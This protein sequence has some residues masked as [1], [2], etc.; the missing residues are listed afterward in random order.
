M[1]CYNFFKTYNNDSYSVLTSPNILIYVVLASIIAAIGLEY[2]QD[3]VIL[4]SMLIS[5]LAVPILHYVTNLYKN[6]FFAFIAHLSNLVIFSIIAIIIGF[7]IS[8]TN[9]NLKIFKNPSSQMKQRADST[10]KIFSLDS[11]IAFICGILVVIASLTNDLVT[12]AGIGIVVAF[13]PPLVNS[14]LYLGS[15]FHHNL[16]NSDTLNDKYVFNNSNDIGFGIINDNVNYLYGSFTS[17]LIAILNFLFFSIGAYSTLH[18]V[19]KKK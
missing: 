17:L 10:I 14:G 11:F 6:N 13:L 16:N 8:I 9:H 1:S 3:S 18:I 4:G 12:L 15:H 5:P 7:I 2:D 19:C